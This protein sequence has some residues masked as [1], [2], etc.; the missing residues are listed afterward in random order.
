[1]HAI[2]GAP[3]VGDES[4]GIVQHRRLLRP[5]PDVRALLKPEPRR[6]RAR[7]HPRE[8]D[9]RDDVVVVVESADVAVAPREE[10]LRYAAASGRVPERHVPEEPPRL[11]ARDRVPGGE[12]V[13]GA[14]LADV[15]SG[16]S[17]HRIPE[18]EVRDGESELVEPCG[19]MPREERAAGETKEVNGSRVGVI[20]EAPVVLLEPPARIPERRSPVES[21]DGTREVRAEVRPGAGFKMEFLAII[22]YAEVAQARYVGEASG[23]ALSGSLEKEAEVHP[24]DS[25]EQ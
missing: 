10:H 1:M 15:K 5:L 20:G 18:P 16:G 17:V 25:G 24:W 13:R 7:R 12:D 22:L 3:E 4:M 2:E 8:R 11:V 23:Y 6:L 21:G 14:L 19:E 9:V